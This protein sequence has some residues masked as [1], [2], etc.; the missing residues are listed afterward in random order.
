MGIDLYVWEPGYVLVCWE[1][2]LRDVSVDRTFMNTLLVVER[3][4]LSPGIRG[5]GPTPLALI[6]PSASSTMETREGIKIPTVL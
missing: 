2:F 5:K 3:E 6:P 1:R 4:E